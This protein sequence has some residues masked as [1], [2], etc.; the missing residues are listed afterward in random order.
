[1]FCIGPNLRKNT[2]N[3]EEMATLYIYRPALFFNA[4]GWPNIHIDDE[5][6]FSL[7]NKGYGVVHVKLGEQYNCSKRIYVGYKLVPRP[8]GIY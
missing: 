6:L 5:K 4:L 7:K 3:P 2:S 8:Y 1:M